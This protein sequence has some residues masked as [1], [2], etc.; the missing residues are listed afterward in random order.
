VSTVPAT[1]Q[2]PAEL[3]PRRVRRRLLE[4]AAVVA[5]IAVLVLVGPGLGSLRHHLAHASAGWLLAGVGLELL[6]ALAYVVVFRAV[7][8]PR[9]R[10]GLSYQIGMA[11]QAANSVLSVSGAGGLALGVWALRRGGMSVEH[12]AR[13]TVAF[14]FLTSMA[15]VGA[16][17]V[18]AG[19]YATGILID[20]RNPALTYTFGAAALLATVLV[21]ALPALLRSGAPLPQAA[22]RSRKLAAA[23][24]FLRYSLVQGIRDGLMLL[25]RRSLGVIVGSLA[26]VG[27]PELLREFGEN[28]YLFYGLALIVMM[29]IR[30]EGLWPSATRRRELHDFAGEL[31]V[32]EP[33]PAV[34][35]EVAAHAHDHRP[36]E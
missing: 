18:F 34:V 6:S 30:P 22:E 27:L 26:L 19:L 10:W 20:D 36:G 17:I 13:R 1:E 29:R 11:E 9:M 15:N 28:R 21:L 24:R 3:S 4:L 2:M 32:E 12:I 31:E 35:A 33:P 14:F 25:R 16:V 7:F 23:L 5:L 8:C